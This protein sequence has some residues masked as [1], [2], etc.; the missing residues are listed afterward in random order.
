MAEL[1]RDVW[2]DLVDLPLRILGSHPRK[3]VPEDALK[4]AVRAPA[5]MWTSRL[6]ESVG[7]G[8]ADAVVIALDMSTRKAGA[9]RRLCPWASTMKGPPYT[10]TAECACR[11]EP[12]VPE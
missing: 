3:G 6:A 8:A 7:D 12:S 10:S 9:V 4:R 5:E 2:D 1:E 11:F